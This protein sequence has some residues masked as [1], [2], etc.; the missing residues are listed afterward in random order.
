MSLDLDSRLGWPADLRPLLERYPRAVWPGHANLG[1]M[2]QFWLSV[3]DQFRRL[4]SAL[5]AANTSLREGTLSAG[6][7][8]SWYPRRLNLFLGG[9]EGHHSIEDYQFFPVLSV[10]E[11]RLGRG[12]EVLESDHESIHAAMTA[13][14]GSATALL[15]TDDQNRDALLKAVERHAGDADTLLGLLARHLEDEEDLIIPIILD[16]GEGVLGMGRDVD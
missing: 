3:H 1:E 14:F 12:F 4:G 6:E 15:Q 13:A 2:A 7:Y 11:P 16:R 10:A 9:L 5:T 8:R